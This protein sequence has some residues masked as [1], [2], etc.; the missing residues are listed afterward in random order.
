M[1]KQSIQIYLALSDFTLYRMKIGHQLNQLYQI[2]H[3]LGLYES[4]L[5]YQISL[6]RMKIK[7]PPCQ[8]RG[9]QNKDRPS[10]DIVGT[11]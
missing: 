8:L 5:L 6:Y 7:V 1:H 3:A 11:C 4:A 9:E 2:C 10:S